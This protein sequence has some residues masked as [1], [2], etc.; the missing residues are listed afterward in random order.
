[1]A[2]EHKVPGVLGGYFTRFDLQV[3]PCRGMGSTI[4]M[5]NTGDL[6]DCLPYFDQLIATHGRKVA[7][8]N[9]FYCIDDGDGRPC[10]LGVFPF[11]HTDAPNNLFVQLTRKAITQ[12]VG[13]PELLINKRDRMDEN[14]LHGYSYAKYAD[15]RLVYRYGTFD[16][17][18]VRTS[19]LSDSANTFAQSDVRLPGCSH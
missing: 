1:M 2:V 9:K 15:G 19:L 6:Y 5:T 3:I 11:S 14:K 8:A 13:Y 12:G 16:Y 17:P 18:L 4:Q 7:G 10:Y